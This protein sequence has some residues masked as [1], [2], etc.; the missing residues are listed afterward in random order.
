MKRDLEPG[1]D[2]DPLVRGTDPPIPILA[3]MSRI[4]NTDKKDRDR[5]PLCVRRRRFDCKNDV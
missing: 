4:R 5:D 1:S 3:K 2:S